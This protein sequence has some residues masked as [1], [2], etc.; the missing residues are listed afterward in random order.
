MERSEA[1]Q[2]IDDPVLMRQLL[3]RI[4]CKLSHA[5]R[6]DG[7]LARA[8]RA[9]HAAASPARNRLGTDEQLGRARVMISLAI[10]ELEAV[11][12]DA[13]DTAEAVRVP[14]YRPAPTPWP[15]PDQAT[16]TA[17]RIAAHQVA[18]LRHQIAQHM[19]WLQGRRDAIQV[20]LT[21]TE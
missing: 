1:W 4:H 20:L 16:C 14:T 8:C 11:D 10:D 18:V 5:T 17:A 21:A 19:A 2:T 3:R 6:A 13:A 7:L 15:R 12:A 9:L